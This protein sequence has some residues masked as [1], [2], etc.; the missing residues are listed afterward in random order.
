MMSG[1]LIS[2]RIPRR[3]RRGIME[4]RTTGADTIVFIHGLYLTARSWEL[5]EKRYTDRGYNVINQSW[6][7]FEGEVE[8]LR[9]DP[10]PIANQSVE[11]ILEHYDRIIRPLERPPIIIGHSFGGAFTQV[12]VSRGLGAAAVLLASATVRG[13]F[14]VPLIT[15]RSNG[16]VLRNPLFRHRAVMPSADE[17]RFAFTNTFP[18]ADSA[19]AYERYAVA[20]SRNVLFTGVNA[21]VNPFTPLKADFKKSDRAPLLF[22]AGGQDHVVPASANRHNAGKYRKSE[23]ITDLVEFPERAHFTA[24]QDGWEEVADVA[25]QWALNPAAELTTA[26]ATPLQRMNQSAA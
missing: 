20:A 23:A 15:L 9:A 4:N 1:A 25:L 8:A 10:T 19:K 5:W 7:G 18:E 17:F 22:I 3:T 26:G 16:K 14:D 12:L 6:P 24:V 13:V 21:N 2:K 11:K